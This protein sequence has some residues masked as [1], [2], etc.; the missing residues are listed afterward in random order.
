MRW[1]ADNY[2]LSVSVANE[3]LLFFIKTSLILTSRETAAILYTIEINLSEKSQG[4]DEEKF[5]PFKWFII[6]CFYDIFRMKG[7]HTLFIIAPFITE[8]NNAWRSLLFH[9][10]INDFRRSSHVLNYS[11]HSRNNP[12]L[13]RNKCRFTIQPVKNG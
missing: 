7:S 9:S 13:V 6:W 5:K 12:E 10:L 1:N 11:G 2:G 3:L 8:S 4:Y